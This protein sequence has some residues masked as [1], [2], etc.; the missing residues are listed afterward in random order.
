[1]FFPVKKACYADVAVVGTLAVLGSRLAASWSVSATASNVLRIRHESLKGAILRVR[2]MV[3]RGDPDQVNVAVDELTRYFG[4]VKG[5]FSQEVQKRLSLQL[6]DLR[7]VAENLRN[8]L[9][10]RLENRDDNLQRAPFK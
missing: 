5:N 6:Q 4:W 9:S 10:L 1:L 7:L 3:A 8:D 2:A